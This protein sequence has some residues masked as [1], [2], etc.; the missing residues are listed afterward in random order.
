MNR[1]FFSDEWGKYCCDECDETFNFN[2][3]IWLTSSYGLCLE[4]YNKLSEE[5][6]KEIR[7]KYE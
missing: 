4:C 5:E 1:K 6:K 2:D 7:N 3:V